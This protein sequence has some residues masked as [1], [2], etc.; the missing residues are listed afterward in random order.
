MVRNL[1]IVLV[2]LLAANTAVFAQSG[3][4]KGKVLDKKTKEPIPFTNIVV[5]NSGTRA[6]GTTSD[7]NGEYTIKPLNPGKYDIKASFVGFK[8][9]LI[10]GFVVRSE[11]IEFQNIEM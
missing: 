8:P 10:K 5:E 3:A 11:K 7:I 6:G 1:L 9:V 2:L 4:L